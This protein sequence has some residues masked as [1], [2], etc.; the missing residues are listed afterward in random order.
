[1][2]DFIDDVPKDGLICD[3][4]CG[5]GRVTA[6][7]AQENRNAMGLDFSPSSLRILRQNVSLPLLRVNNLCLPLQEKTVDAVISTGV[8]HHTPDPLLALQENCRVL[9]PGGRLFSK[10]YRKGSYYNFLYTFVGGAM[11]ACRKLGPPG[12]FLV[13]NALF[14]L[15]RLVTS[16]IRRGRSSDVGHRRNIYENYFLKSLVSFPRRM[17]LERILAQSNMEIVAFEKTPQMN[18]YV[19]QKRSDP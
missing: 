3:I 11:R 5:P 10:T 18:F 9:K 6:Y 16:A 2:R 17:D 12:R 13:N 19:A 1:M 4:G 14:T 7:L 8:I 15:Y